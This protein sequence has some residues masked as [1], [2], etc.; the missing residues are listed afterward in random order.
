[1]IHQIY[2][3]VIIATAQPEASLTINIRDNCTKFIHRLLINR[4]QT[5]LS[6]QAVNDHVHLF[7]AYNPN[8]RL[9]D[10]IHEIK[11]ESETLINN[12]KLTPVPFS[13]QRGFAV[14]SFAHSQKN[15]VIRFVENQPEFHEKRS[16]EEEF[17]TL[18][19]KC[20]L[21]I[22]EPVFEFFNPKN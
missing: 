10:L 13:W 15:E 7:F 4:N 17:R 2:L 12:F 8:V 18:L 20:E 16:F 6:V 21:E 5:P 19:Q 22:D 14:F 3:Q 11:L 1:M 9:A